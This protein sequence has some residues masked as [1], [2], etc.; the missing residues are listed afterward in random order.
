MKDVMKL[1]Y[2][3]AA[4]GVKYGTVSGICRMRGTE[5]V[6]LKFTDWVSDRFNNWADLYE[7]DIISNE[8]LFCFDEASTLIAQRTGRDKPQRFRTYS[9]II[10]TDGAWH[11]CT[12]ADKAHIADLILRGVVKVLCLTDSGQ[13]HIFFKHRMG[14][15]QLDDTHIEPNIPDFAHLHATMQQ[16]VSLG[17]AQEQIKKGNYSQAVILKV[18]LAVWQDLENILKPRRG[19][20]IFD[21]AAWLMFKID[22]SK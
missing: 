16:L 15:W 5:G 17:F 3:N 2:D 20:P 10:T 22:E 11:I 12:K 4:N 7:G 14:F 21:L 19:E 18:G 1:L 8:A 9:H 13:K 6:G